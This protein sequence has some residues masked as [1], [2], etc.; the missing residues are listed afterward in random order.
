MWPVTPL[1]LKAIG[2]WRA[3]WYTA[4]LHNP[5]AVDDVAL[6]IEDGTVT[7][8][9]S[10]SCRRILA[11]TVPPGTVTADQLGAPGAEISVTQTV[12]YIDRSIE[13]VPVGVFG[14]DTDAL[15]K[16]RDG[17]LSL[18]GRDRWA[19]VQANKLGNPYTGE[20]VVIPTNPTWAEIKRLTEGG[21]PNPAY[22]FPG[23]ASVDMSA[24]TPVGLVYWDDNDREAAV[25]K[26]CTSG[27]VQVFF[28]PDGLGML[29]R[30][31]VAYPD[32]VPDW[33]VAGGLGGALLDSE[34]ARDRT[35]LFNAVI[36]NSSAV[37]LYVPQVV[38]ANTDPAD[39]YSIYGWYGFRPKTVTSPS[40]YTPTQ[41]NTAAMVGLSRLL[42]RASTLTMDTGVNA[43]LEADD[44]LALTD[45]DTGADELRVV[46]SFTVP[47]TPKGTQQIHCRAVLPT[48]YEDLM[49]E[50]GL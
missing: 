5:G 33:A 48:G 38:T 8:D 26:L 9:G 13:T 12:R 19:Q 22:P 37:G 20:P 25:G 4:T 39:P 18:T 34:R 29:R 50:L 31:P 2:T 49:R 23:W 11:L 41:T 45:P 3:V 40:F 35:G 42:G 36:V 10:A 7:V 6:D 47:L 30:V 44:V 32:S 46:E 21:W 43:A 28:R 14:V 17:Q 15:T 27:T 1:Y 16:G 24:T